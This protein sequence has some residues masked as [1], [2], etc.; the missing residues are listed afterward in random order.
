MFPRLV[1]WRVVKNLFNPSTSVHFSLS[2]FSHSLI[3]RKV[4]FY[5]DIL[6]QLSILFYLCVCVCVFTRYLSLN[7]LKKKSHD[8]QNSLLCSS[9]LLNEVKMFFVNLLNS[10]ACR[11]HLNLMTV[12]WHSLCT[13]HNISSII[14]LQK[15]AGVP[16]AN[17]TVLY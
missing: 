16:H 2:K 5:T 6:L 1:K 4:L 9:L 17:H 14:T 3:F 15:K 13:W 7:E 11:I 8:S 10:V 12:C